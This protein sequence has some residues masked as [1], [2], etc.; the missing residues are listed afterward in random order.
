MNYS[1]FSGRVATVPKV[2]IVQTKDDEQIFVCTFVISVPEYTDLSD[3]KKYNFYECIA[4]NETAQKIHKHF[5][6]TAKVLTFG[7][8]VNHT[9]KDINNTPHFTNILLIQNIEFG[10]T[11]SAINRMNLDTK[12]PDFTVLSDL[13]EM[14][15]AYKKI[16][17]NGFLCIDEND[18]Y[19]IASSYFE[20][21]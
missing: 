2:A 1:I 18:Y 11:E 21:V 15:A 17:E 12:L 13:K 9:F 5:T 7:K 10:D 6:K 20:A 8:M 19:N 3:G 4:F 14:D 16:C